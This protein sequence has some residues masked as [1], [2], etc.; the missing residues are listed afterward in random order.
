MDT[1]SYL[2]QFKQ[3]SET[4]VHANK[5]H[6]AFCEWTEIDW[7][8][9]LWEVDEITAGTSIV[10]LTNNMDPDLL[11]RVADSPFCS[12]RTLTAL[13]FNN[14]VEVR[15][16]VADNHKTPLS[17]LMMLAEDESDDVR[18]QLAENHNIPDRVLGVLA[19]DANPYV[20]SRAEATLQRKQEEYIRMAA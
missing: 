13:A 4:Q 11:L 2:S 10:K 16:A 12:A 9:L 15:C 20:A 18:Y 8:G 3:A 19:E 17:A 7:A 6:D 1:T 5:H 14:S